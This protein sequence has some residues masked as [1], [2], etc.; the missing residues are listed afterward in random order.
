MAV[1]EIPACAGTVSVD[2]L[3]FRFLAFSNHRNLRNLRIK[4]FSGGKR[5]RKKG[6][7]LFFSPNQLFP[8]C[9]QPQHLI[10]LTIGKQTGV[11]RDLGSMKL[12]PEATVEMESQRPL[13]RFTHWEGMPNLV[14]N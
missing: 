8:K 3:G 13:F 5:G 1:C 12:Q 7:D 9:C 14:E 6:T 10:Q 11:T 2:R 4:V